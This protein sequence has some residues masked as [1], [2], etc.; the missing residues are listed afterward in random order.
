VKRYSKDRTPH[1]ASERSSLRPDKAPSATTS[2]AVKK[3]LIGCHD[4]SCFNTVKKADVDML[5][6]CDF[7]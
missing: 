1:K 3:T 5:P 6:S 4:N 7:V 2:V